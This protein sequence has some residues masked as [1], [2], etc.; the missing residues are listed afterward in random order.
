MNWMM[1]A[2]PGPLSMISFTVGRLVWSFASAASGW[3]R[4]TLWSASTTMRSSMPNSGSVSRPIQ[5]SVV[6]SVGNATRFFS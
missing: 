4:I 2:L 3:C 1:A 5:P 6:A